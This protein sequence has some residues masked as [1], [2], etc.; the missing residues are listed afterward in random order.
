MRTSIL[1]A[2]LAGAAA[3]VADAPVAAGQIREG[4]RARLADRLRNPPAPVASVEQQAADVAAA[5]AWLR[6]HAVQQGID[7]DR[8]VLAGHSAGAQLVALVG[9][10]PRYLAAAGLSLNAI[11][12][13]I[14]L[15]GAG[16]DV[17]RKIAD[18][19]PMLRSTYRD[20]FGDDLDRQRALSPVFQAAAPNAPAFLLVHVDRA[21]S[22]SQSEALGA[23]L[24]R[25]G[26][27]V[28][29]AAFDGK[30]LQGHIAINRRLGE[31][32]YPATAVVDA[33][34]TKELAR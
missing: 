25:A 18:A 24:R 32:D 27:D 8:I 23:A 30:G 13:V 28:Q 21:D 29:V 17:P 31:T 34:L 7:A 14:A 15:D 33:W 6:G 1:I 22:T 2:M 12:G 20:A 4:L 26:A 10:D 9:T 11:R 16:Y 19:G 3:T 5:L